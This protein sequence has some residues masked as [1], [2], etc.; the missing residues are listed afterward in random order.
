MSRL[1]R[2]LALCGAALT[3]GAFS[4]RPA[5]SQRNRRPNII[6]ILADDLG[7]GDI[8]SYGQKEIKTPVL[9]RLAAEGT[10]YTQFYAG[11]TV[12]APS[13]CALMTGYHTGHGI[14]RG[15]R[16]PEIALRPEDRSW[17]QVLKD[18]GYATGIFGKWGVGPEGSTGT[19]LKKGFDTFFG[20][21]TQLQAHNYYPAQ[22]W[23]DEKPYPLRNQVTAGVSTNKLDYVPD[24]TTREALRFIDQHARQPF[25]L[26]LPYTLPH[27]NNEAKNK[28]MEVPSDAPYSDKPWP[29]PQKNHAAMIT[30]LDTYVGQVLQRVKEL[31]LEKDTLVMFTSDNGPHREGGADPEFF[32]SAGPLRGIKRDSYEGGIRVPLLAKWPGHVAAGAASDAVWAFWDVLPTLAEV[33]GGTAPAGIDGVSMVPDLLTLEEMDRKRS[34]HPPLYWEFHERGFDQAVRMGDWKYIRLQ[35]PAGTKVELYNL[36][37]DRGETHDVAKEHPDVIAR[38]ETYLKTARTESPYWPVKAP[39]E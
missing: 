22:I 13:R 26:Y 31:G 30:R 3:L 20:Y 38:V 1:L 19:P 27:A 6:F 36:K 7:Y 2:I 21:Y 4:A 11:C 37:E 9:D 24:L 17:G 35:R 29:Q 32:H 34:P 33:G 28:G 14:I 10:R 25:F 23:L 8:G 39:G 15:N 16:N 5:A 12:C 18:A